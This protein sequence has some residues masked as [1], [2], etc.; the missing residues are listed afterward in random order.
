V[1]APVA[2]VLAVFLALAGCGYI[3][4]V[5]PPSAQIPNSIADLSVIERG[6]QL[7]VQFT[8][9]AHTTDNIPIKKLANIDLRIGAAA[10]PFDAAAWAKSAEVVEVPPLAE[11]RND[12]GESIAMTKSVPVGDRA[13]KRV[14]VMVR[15]AVR[16][17]EHY[18]GWSNPVTI[19]VV[20]PLETP[21][22]T[23]EPTAAGYKLT[24]PDE[25]AGVHY[26][27]FRQWTNDKS[28]IELGTA[29]KNEY[30]D[31][32]SQWD[33]PYT[34]SVVATKGR[35]E[36]L[37]WIAGKPVSAA[38][39]YAPSVPAELSAFPSSDGIELTWR[40]SP[41][42]DLAGYFVYRSVNGGAFEKQGAL[43]NVPIYSDRSVEHGKTYRYAVSAIDRKANESEKSAPVEVAF[44]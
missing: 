37:P 30:I 13:G 27:V 3:G 41:E 38:D 23:I 10:N 24:W 40:R 7:V 34:Y 32:T 1:R 22:V 15:T 35:A 43:V 29:D 12:E 4:P 20:T 26:R 6:D 17:G 44:P 25:G 11:N 31:R 2:A 42:S 19:D 9:P 33:T 39:I 36:S 28:A 21:D 14:A 8:T 16:N 5:V 18:S